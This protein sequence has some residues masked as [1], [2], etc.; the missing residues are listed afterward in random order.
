[1][2]PDVLS[3]RVSRNRRGRGSAFCSESTSEDPPS[4]GVNVN[5]NHPELQQE[6][7]SGER[8]LNELGY[9]QDSLHIDTKKTCV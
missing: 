4:P 6:E 9:K 3:F 1:M 7:D 8:R 5:P 2:E